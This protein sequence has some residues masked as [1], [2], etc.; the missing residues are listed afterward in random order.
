MTRAAWRPSTRHPQRDSLTA[1]AGHPGIVLI[2]QAE[3]PHQLDPEDPD[4]A[5]RLPGYQAD[6]VHQLLDDGVLV[7]A[8][9]V[10]V[11]LDEDGEPVRGCTVVPAHS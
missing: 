11:Q 8:D 6:A 5:I 4:R 1:M 9:T 2:G 7:R 10:A 3:H